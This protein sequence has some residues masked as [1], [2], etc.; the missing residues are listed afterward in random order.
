MA[1]SCVVM[2]Q[3]LVQRKLTVA[4]FARVGLFH[5][6]LANLYYLKVINLKSLAI[7]QHLSH[8]RML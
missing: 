2:I 5:L 3:S 8:C 6:I 4:V 1:Y 7:Q